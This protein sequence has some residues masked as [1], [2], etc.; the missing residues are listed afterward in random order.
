ML[1]PIFRFDMPRRKVKDRSRSYQSVR[2]SA[3]KRATS[4]ANGIKS[5]KYNFSSTLLSSRGVYLRKS[6][7]QSDGDRAS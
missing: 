5:N 6:A 2:M 4:G 7:F 3:A 1:K